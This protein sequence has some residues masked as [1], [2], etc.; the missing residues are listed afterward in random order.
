LRAAGIWDRAARAFRAGALRRFRS[1]LSLS[2][3]SYVSLSCWLVVI[4]SA[5]IRVVSM[6]HSHSR[7]WLNQGLWRVL[8][9]LSRVLVLCGDRL[10]L[11][12]QRDVDSGPM[13][14]GG[15]A[16]LPARRGRS[17]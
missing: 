6:D 2:L 14:R 1:F 9:T 5:M 4:G 8:T 16:Y 13:R 11:P 10:P 12:H 17:R 7:E 3:V 15:R